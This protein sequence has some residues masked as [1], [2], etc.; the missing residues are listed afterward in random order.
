MVVGSGDTAD[1]RLSD[2][3]VSHTHLQLEARPDG[4]F[5]RD[6]GSTNGTFLG[7]ARIETAFVEAQAVISLGRTLL[8]VS[9]VT[10]EQQVDGP[11]AF[12][13]LVATSATM[14]RLFGLVERLAPT[15]TP[16]I[17]LGET[18]TG[19]EGLAR[20]LHARSGRRGPLVVVD[21]GAFAPTLIESELFG[22]ARGAF[23]GAVAE[24]AG[25]FSEAEG[26]T[27]FLDEVG[28]LPLDLQ[29]RLLRALEGHQ[30]KR[31]G[32][33]RHRTIDVRI[34]AATNRDLEAEVKAGR[35]RSDLYFRLAV[36]ALH[37]PPL[38]ERREDIPVLVQA[39]IAQ[40]GREPLDL[41]ADLMAKLTDYQWP[42]NVRELRNVVARA[43]VSDQL[44]LDNVLNRAVAPAVERPA[45]APA[46]LDERF[47]EAK[48]RVVESFTREYLVA[49]QARHEGNVSQMARASGLARS[50]LHDLLA[51][52]SLARAPKA[53]DGQD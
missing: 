51:R 52:Y 7:G 5:V 47:K 33:D 38:R 35:F 15:E 10:V 9:M 32:E 13:Q 26:G 21:C 44:S 43:V 36:A 6:L 22:H 25:A 1:L 39:M 23:T 2:T 29:P 49:L 37:V 14:R 50:Y 17:L 34:V 11:Q 30:V 45:V 27:L 3:A 24:R 19:K 41:S 20:A 46:S 8:S 18:G 31:V 42:G 12:E 16:V 53:G 28:E 40:F 4:V 48:E